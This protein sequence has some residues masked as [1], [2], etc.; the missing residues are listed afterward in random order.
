MCDV[1]HI[2]SCQAKERHWRGRE[3]VGCNI[4]NKQWID[5]CQVH[6]KINNTQCSSQTVMC[7]YIEIINQN[8]R[9]IKSQYHQT[10]WQQQYPREREKKQPTKHS[11]TAFRVFIFWYLLKVLSQFFFTFS[12][13]FAFFFFCSM[14]TLSRLV[15][16]ICSISWS[17]FGESV[18]S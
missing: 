5:D 8:I 16:H 11:L 3:R 14:L 12:I 17:A 15:I 1:A 6:Y 2:A 9:K 18:V 4:R 13:S 10:D 7:N